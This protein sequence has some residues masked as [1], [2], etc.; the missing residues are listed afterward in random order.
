MTLKLAD[1]ADRSLSTSGMIKDVDVPNLHFEEPLVHGAD[2]GAQGSMSALT[3]RSKQTV[4]PGHIPGLG[5]WN[6][7]TAVNFN[8]STQF[9]NVAPPS[10]G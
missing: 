4:R 9:R 10:G 5:A 6:R 8:T 3:W 7:G 2:T 1:I